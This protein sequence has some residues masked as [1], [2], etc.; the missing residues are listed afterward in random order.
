MKIKKKKKYV[1]KGMIESMNEEN[2][3]K[4]LEENLNRILQKGKAKQEA[5][6][7]KKIEESQIKDFNK[8]EFIYQLQGEINVL[9]ERERKIIQM[10]SN[11]DEPLEPEYP[12]ELDN[13]TLEILYIALLYE[14]PNA[15]SKYY[16]E[17]DLCYFSSIIVLNLYKSVIFKEGEKSA[18]PQLKE[19]FNFPKAIAELYDIKCMMKDAPLYKKYDF[20]VIYRELK[21]LFILKKNYIKAPT[22]SMQE[23]IL[24]IKSYDRYKDMTAEEVEAAIK[25]INVTNRLSQTILNKDIAKFLLNDKNDL[26]EGVPLPF[27]IL[28]EVFKGFRKGEIMAYA[29]PSNAGKSRFTVDLACNIAFLH[30]HKVLIVSNEMTEEKMRLCLLT[31]IINNPEIQKLHGQVIRK[32]EGELLEF[33]FR[34]DKNTNEPL[35]EDG[36]IKRIDGESQDDYINRLQKTSEE[37]RKIMDVIT[38]VN[39][40]INNS[41][42]FVHLTE[43]SNN[44]LHEVISNYMYKDGIEFVFYDTLKTDVNN[45]GNA[46]ELK[47]TATL[48]SE[49]TQKFNIFIGA[50]IQLLENNTSPINLT[51]NDLS[52]SKNVKEVFDTLSLFKQIH[53]KNYPEY[54]FSNS[55][56]FIECKDIEDSDDPDVRYY[57]CVVDKNRAGAKPKLLFKLNLAYNEW[58]ELGYV[59]LK[60][61]YKSEE[62]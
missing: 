29:M 44:D 60:E 55:D 17:K 40:Q 7:I 22:K 27:P 16:F 19:G 51:I 18:P 28:T 61:K 24:E 53:R 5:E 33:K 45:I 59:R 46:E 1:K 41:V 25:Q 30:K 36:F 35:D 14:S 56:R 31:T 15:I 37:F 62:E 21:K 2:Q 48:L 52:V 57:V 20:E 39:K 8:D 3:Y 12:K 6:R 42:Y 49:L 4:E 34:P 13:L 50:S 58:I 9:E 23:K 43:Y 11:S 26:R 10:S 54:E 47:K 32:N 38:W